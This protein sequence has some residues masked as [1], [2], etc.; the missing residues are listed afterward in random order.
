[1]SYEAELIA[2]GKCPEVVPIMTEDGPATGRCMAPITDPEVAACEGH[3]A[4]IRSWH[5]MSE[6][7]KRQWE[8][9]RDN[10]W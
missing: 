6:W 8:L 7:D 9:D 1:M 3:A 2:E 4:E 10:G 5:A